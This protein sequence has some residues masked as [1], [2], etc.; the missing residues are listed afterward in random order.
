MDRTTID[1][2]WAR[3]SDVVSRDSLYAGVLES[4]KH[5]IFAPKEGLGGHIAW[6]AIENTEVGQRP[7]RKF[8]VNTSRSLIW[9]IHREPRGPQSF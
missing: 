6:V 7:A 3:A 8:R 2:P 9:V 4:S 5:V 1:A